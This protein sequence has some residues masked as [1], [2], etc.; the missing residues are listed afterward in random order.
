MADEDSR[1][2]TDRLHK[3]HA[4][5]RAAY[6]WISHHT[7]SQSSEGSPAPDFIRRG[8]TGGLLVGLSREFLLDEK[9]TELVAYLYCLMDGPPVDAL[10]RSRELLDAERKPGLMSAFLSG[11]R[12]ASR[13]AKDLESRKL[14][15]NRAQRNPARGA[16]F[17]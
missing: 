12:E 2:T 16:K 1:Y 14:P 5:A 7:L 10:D 17:S 3:A 9:E 6:L 8:L 13:L 4:M 15:A 11:L